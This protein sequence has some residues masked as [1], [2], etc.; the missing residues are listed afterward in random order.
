MATPNIYWL[1]NDNFLAALAFQRAGMNTEKENLQTALVKYG[2]TSTDLAKILK[3]TPVGYPPGVSEVV[4]KWESPDGSEQIRDEVSSSS[5][6]FEDWDS[7][8]NLSLLAA[9]N[10]FNQ[11]NLERSHEIFNQALKAFD[12]TGFHDK[13]FNKTYETYKLAIAIYVGQQI[14]YEFLEKDEMVEIL[15][16][17]QAESGGF[18]TH[19]DANFLPAGNT[20]TETTSWAILSLLSAGCS[21]DR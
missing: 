4:V 9:L 20:N 18:Y 1:Y 3:R 11:R 13:A 14:N 6:F 21:T 2:A 8:T 15:L 7:Y 12:G 10:E 17:V 16:S 19:Y 5:A